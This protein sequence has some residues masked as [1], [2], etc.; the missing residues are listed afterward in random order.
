MSA[1]LHTIV[2]GRDAMACRFEVVFN[3][4]EVA[5]A[6]EL[7]VDALDLVDEI[8]SR[9]T[10]YRD[11]SELA[12][13]NA[14]AAAGWQPVAADLFALLAH[15]RELHDLTGG[16]FDCAAGA[17]VRTWGFLQRQ[18]RTP[19]D[20]E[21]A[22]ARGRSG[23]AFVEL[24]PA[25]SRIRFTRPGI[26]VNLGAIGK[27]W[28]ID[29]AIEL[30]RDRGVA[31]VLV[32]GGQSSV[33]AAG[34]QGPDIPGRPG[35]PGKPGW[36]VGLRHPLRPGRRLATITLRDQ[37][38]G[39]SGS[40]TQFFIDRGKKL[41]HILDPRS[42]VPAAGVLS[43]TVIAPTAADADALST[44]LYVLGPDGLP[45]IAAAGGPVGAILVVPGGT[46]GS[47]RVLTANLAEEAIAFEAAEGI[48]R[49]TQ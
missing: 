48:E 37:A 38:L 32:H 16:A 39:T 3:A 31:S 19:A 4:G 15:A 49:E 1:D 44:A 41:G 26:E 12:R 14:T 10:V 30:L 40:G 21:L 29:R 45:T 46:A 18:G 11:T 13:L 2:V 17:L 9:I 22:A 47:V 23:L 28:A 6:A 33:R 27:G 20:E 8:E 7:G 24:D 42:G 5:D 25:G 35:W 34:V 43:A 36:N